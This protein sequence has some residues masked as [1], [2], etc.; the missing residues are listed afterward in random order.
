LNFSQ[1]PRILRKAGSE[2]VAQWGEDE[3]SYKHDDGT[4]DGIEEVEH[5]DCRHGNHEEKAA[6]DA[7]IGEGFM[8]AFEDSVTALN[9]FRH[10]PPCKVRHEQLIDWE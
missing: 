5:P 10:K 7:H 2:F 1:H 4:D 8:Q 6:F 9:Y 3:A